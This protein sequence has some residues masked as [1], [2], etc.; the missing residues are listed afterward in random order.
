MKSLG[1]ER[2]ELL[3]VKV[4]FCLPQDAKGIAVQ[5]LRHLESVLKAQR[6]QKAKKFSEFLNLRKKLVKE[7][8]IRVK[9]RQS[10]DVVS[11]LDGQPPGLLG[12]GLAWGLWPVRIPFL[13]RLPAQK[14]L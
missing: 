10:R 13:L 9:E 3:S 2:A 11:Q 8:T 12:M 6:E 1:E 5:T 7:A 14:R 4:S